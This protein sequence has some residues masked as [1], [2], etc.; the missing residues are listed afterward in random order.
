[1][2]EGPPTPAD[3]GAAPKEGRGAPIIGGLVV[4]MPLS[5]GPPPGGRATPP[6]GPAPGGA[7]PTGRRGGAF[8]AAAGGPVLA[9]GGIPVGD[10]G[11]AWMCI[12]D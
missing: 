1:M 6:G 4:G 7:T 10:G 9:G 2:G 11:C 12:Q 3:G 8:V 5:V